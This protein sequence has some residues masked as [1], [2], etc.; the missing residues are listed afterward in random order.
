[1]AGELHKTHPDIPKRLKRA[2]GY[3][4]SI[5]AMLDK[6]AEDAKE[7]ACGHLPA[8]EGLHVGVGAG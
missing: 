4:R 8:L 7:H 6:V 5:V 2:E 3:I 1:M